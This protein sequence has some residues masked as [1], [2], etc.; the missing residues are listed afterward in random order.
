VEGKPLNSYGITAG[1]GK[2]LSGLISIYG[3]YEYGIRGNNSYNQ[4]KE[5]YN[6]YIIGFTLKEYWFNFRKYGKYQ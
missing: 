1:F 2:N 5:Q 4:I 6:Q 3:G